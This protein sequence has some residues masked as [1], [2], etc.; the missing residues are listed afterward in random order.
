M[1]IFFSLLNWS[2]R[3]DNKAKVTGLVAEQNWEPDR[4]NNDGQLKIIP[5]NLSSPT[6]LASPN[7]HLWTRSVL[8]QI[9]GKQCTAS[10]P[11]TFYYVSIIFK[12]FNKKIVP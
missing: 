10:T 2:E 5:P 11:L 3:V 9:L 4:G 1:C 7:K 12:F 8:V 6:P